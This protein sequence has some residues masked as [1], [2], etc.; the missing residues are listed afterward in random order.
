MYKRQVEPLKIARLSPKN[1]RLMRPQL[2]GFISTREEF[3]K[4]TKELFEMVAGGIDVS[5]YKTYKLSDVAQAH[6]DIEG[7]KTTGKLLL[8]P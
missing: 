4:Y 8:R 7:R 3:E 5:I 6:Q 2:F 1:I